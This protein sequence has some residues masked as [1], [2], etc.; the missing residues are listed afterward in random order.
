MVVKRQLCR[1]RSFS[2]LQRLLGI[3]WMPDVTLCMTLSIGGKER[4]KG[5]IAFSTGNHGKAAA[6]VAV[7]AV[8]PAT[9]CLSEH[10]APCRVEMIK[11]L[12]AAV[13]VKGRSQDEAE[14]NYE[15]LLHSRGAA[16][17]APFDDPMI[18]AGQG[19]IAR[20][21]LEGLPYPGV[22]K[23]CNN[24]ALKFISKLFRFLDAP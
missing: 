10:V 16:P 22:M 20:E 4:E 3:H 18:I 23:I 5:V 19:T 13:S 6:Y 14:K 7:R 11:N 8:V 1:E 9:I 12:G 2:G 17:V 21:I 15:E 24:Q